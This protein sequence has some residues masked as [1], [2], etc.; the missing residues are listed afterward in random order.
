MRLE[1][2]IK[3]AV[4]ATFKIITA[5]LNDKGVQADLAAELERGI[6]VP[7]RLAVNS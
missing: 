2:T 5:Y 3:A 1:A 6:N 7:P 4:P